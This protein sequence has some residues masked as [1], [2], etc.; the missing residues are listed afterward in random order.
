MTDIIAIYDKL[1]VRLFRPYEKWELRYS[2]ATSDDLDFRNAEKHPPSIEQLIADERVAV[3]G[4][5]TKAVL[6]LPNTIYGYLALVPIN[7]Q[8][9]L[10]YRIEDARAAVGRRFKN[11][12]YEKYHPALT[13]IEASSICIAALYHHEH[14]KAYE[15][16]FPQGKYFE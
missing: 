4:I 10:W 14:L 11:H 15:L 1:T 2:R 6:A 13:R 12:V 16:S 7:T 9:A 8:K 5:I 3:D